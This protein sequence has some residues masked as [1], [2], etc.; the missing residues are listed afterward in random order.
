ML[1]SGVLI[2]YHIEREE[3][4]AWPIVQCNKYGNFQ[5]VQDYKSSM[6]NLQYLH[7]VFEMSTHLIAEIWRN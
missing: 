5:Q 1:V 6:L 2:Q 3:S 7:S 4:M